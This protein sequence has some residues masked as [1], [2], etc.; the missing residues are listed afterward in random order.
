MNW[1]LSFVPLAFQFSCTFSSKFQVYP[2]N[3]H[4][5]R[6]LQQ[7]PKHVLVCHS[8]SKQAL[9][10]FLSRSLIAWRKLCVVKVLSQLFSASFTLSD[11]IL[12]SLRC[13]RNRTWLCLFTVRW[14]ALVAAHVCDTDKW[15][16]SLL[17]FGFYSSPCLTPN[18]QTKPS[19][20]KRY[21]IIF[22]SACVCNVPQFILD[23]RFTPVSW[24]QGFRQSRDN[25]L[26]P[27]WR[28][29]SLIA[30]SNTACSVA[31]RLWTAEGPF[32]LVLS[33]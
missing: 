12:L 31:N 21:V 33:R 4:H 1:T 26:V 5:L 32:A 24:G 30:C 8:V 13:L 17:W 18:L 19:R 28:S 11:F 16:R 20:A 10:A 9:R 2:A 22:F 29:N 23:E 15:N 25:K 3:V 14:K 6:F 7:N 27:I